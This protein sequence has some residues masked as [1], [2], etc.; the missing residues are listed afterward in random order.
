[1]ELSGEG[2]PQPVLQPVSG[3]TGTDRL[4]VVRRAEQCVGGGGVTEA[5]GRRVCRVR[6]PASDTCVRI[7][8]SLL[9]GGL[10]RLSQAFGEAYFPQYKLGLVLVSK[11]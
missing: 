9:S 5:T 2:P 4:D 3:G 8:P 7:L 11:A 10:I 6:T 1:M